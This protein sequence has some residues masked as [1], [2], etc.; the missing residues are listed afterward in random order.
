MLQPFEPMRK[1]YVDR[2]IRYKKHYLV[3]QSYRR[4]ASPF[5]ETA[6]AD[7]L[8]TAYSDI[9]LAKGHLAAL[10]NDRY[11]AIVDLTKPEHLKKIL[12]LLSEDSG[13]RL[14]WAI[15]RSKEKLESDLADNY[16]DNIRRYVANHTQWKIARDATV[17]PSLQLIFGELFIIL[18]HKHESRRIT[19]EQL[20][21]S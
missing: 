14:F 9:G 18:K 5:T 19:F 1:I 17:S 2:L 3:S 15:V 11:G 16:K 20:E 8:L 6:A 10:K 12:S 13:Y 4:A 21:K 7:L